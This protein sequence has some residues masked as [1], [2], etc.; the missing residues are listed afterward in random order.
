MKMHERLYKMLGLENFH[1]RLSTWDPEDPKG[2][3]NML[4]ILKLGKK[5]KIWFALRW[6]D[7]GFLFVEVPGEAAFYGP[8][9]DFQM[10]T[11]TGRE[12]TI[13]TNQ[14]DF[15]VPKRMNLKIHRCR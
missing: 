6:K 14:F 3:K 15:A 1:M 9:I 8:K 13:S 12:E 10:K 11:V 5:R 2:K 4:M 7:Q